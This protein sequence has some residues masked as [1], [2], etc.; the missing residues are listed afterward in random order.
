MIAPEPATYDSGQITVRRCTLDGVTRWSHVAQ[1]LGR[2]VDSVRAEFDPSYPRYHIWAP[3]R[4]PDPEMAPPDN[5]IETSSPYI[6]GPDM[7][8]K[9]MT[10]LARG[11]ASA[12]T[13]AIFIGHGLGSVKARLSEMATEGKVEHTARQPYTWSLKA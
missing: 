3:S 8:A 5:E 11:A 13:I 1:Q 12:E 10:C 7:R 2:S 4:E 9:I 6:K